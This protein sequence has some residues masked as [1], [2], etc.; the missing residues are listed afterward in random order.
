MPMKRGH[1]GQEQGKKMEVLGK[2]TPRLVTGMKMDEN[3]E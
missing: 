2:K 1:L 3:E